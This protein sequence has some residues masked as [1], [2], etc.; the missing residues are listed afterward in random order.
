MIFHMNF[1][2]FS[3]HLT[4]FLGKCSNLI[5]ILL[6]YFT[7]FTINVVAFPLPTDDMPERKKI[8]H[9]HNLLQVLL[10]VCVCP[11]HFY[12]FYQFISLS[13]SF[14]RL[15]PITVK[16]ELKSNVNFIQFNLL[17]ADTTP[18]FLCVTYMNER[19]SMNGHVQ[20]CGCS[21]DAVWYIISV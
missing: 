8:K 12:F 11:E 14:S 15:L 19:V 1:Q 16:Y 6:I 18:D 13:S 10:C 2:V 3:L 7:Y 17:I 5:L 21:L 4:D 9:T 20:R